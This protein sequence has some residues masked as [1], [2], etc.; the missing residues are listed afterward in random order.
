MRKKPYDRNAPF[1]KITDACR[2]TGLSRDYLRNGV[3]NGTIPSVKSGKV[4]YINIPAFLAM[5]N[6]VTPGGEDI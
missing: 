3:R 1:Q 4:C 6:A 5:H 2:T